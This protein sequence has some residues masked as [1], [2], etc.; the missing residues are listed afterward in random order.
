M[1]IPDV[2]ALSRTMIHHFRQQDDLMM[3]SFLAEMILARKYLAR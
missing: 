3:T 2:P 1:G